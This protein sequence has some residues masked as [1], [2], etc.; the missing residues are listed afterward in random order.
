MINKVDSFFIECLSYSRKLIMSFTTIKPLAPA[1]HHYF[2][3]QY[4]K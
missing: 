2:T 4:N 1:F 3:E